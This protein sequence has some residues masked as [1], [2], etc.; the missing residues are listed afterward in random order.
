MNIL[1]TKKITIGDVIIG[2]DAPIAL[3]TGPCQLESRD[4]AMFIAKKYCQCMRTNR[5][6]IYL[7]SQL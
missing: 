7:Q 1:H 6:Q 2:G 3:I 4:H 5:K